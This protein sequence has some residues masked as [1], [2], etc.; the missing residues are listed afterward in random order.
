MSTP[1]PKSTPR[2]PDDTDQETGEP[3]R[4]TDPSTDTGTNRTHPLPDPTADKQRP[5]GGKHAE[6]SPYTAGQQ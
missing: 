6:K 3:G 2:R 5:E 4:P 1:Q